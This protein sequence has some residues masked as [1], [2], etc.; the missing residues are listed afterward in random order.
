MTKSIHVYTYLYL[1][2]MELCDVL[3]CLV[4]SDSVLRRHRVQRLQHTLHYLSG[5]R[6]ISFYYPTPYRGG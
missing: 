2:W 3:V 1:F 4:A 6:A 5:T